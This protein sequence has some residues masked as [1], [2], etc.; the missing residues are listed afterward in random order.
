MGVTSI[1]NNIYS[2]YFEK[3]ETGSINTKAIGTTISWGKWI[4][5][6]VGFDF[7]DKAIT[8]HLNRMGVAHKLVKGFNG[9]IK[10]LK[11]LD[12]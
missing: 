11:I 5:G 10:I 4:C 2:F 9:S 8:E 7:D 6:S 3:G 12:D 1:A